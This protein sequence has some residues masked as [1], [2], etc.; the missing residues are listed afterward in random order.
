M[1]GDG[2]RLPE[3][4]SYL[5]PRVVADLR[6]YGRGADGGYILPEKALS[7]IDAI[8]SFGVST[9]WSLEEELFEANPSL[10]IHAYD[11]SVSD[12]VFRRALKNNIVKFLGGKSSLAAVRERYRTYAGYKQFFRGRC[13]HYPQKIYNRR[14]Y[15]RDATVADAFERL[16]G[17]DHVFLKMDIEG[18]E[19]R[20]I[21]QILDYA[22]RIDLMTIEFHETDPLRLVFE[23]NVKAIETRFDLIHIHGNNIAG[24]AEDG[25]PDA[26]EITFLNKRFGTPAIY[27][28]VLPIHG[29]DRPNDPFRPDLP[30]HFT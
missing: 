15:A 23:Q 30:L 14:E 28:D 7:G 8:L 3:S 20:V 16:Q 26:P 13:I 12:K 2:P 25:F 27:R 21:P 6:R 22:D 1:S 24:A 11:H 9:D 4:L 29:L 18:G 19:Y 5:N 10:T 17:F